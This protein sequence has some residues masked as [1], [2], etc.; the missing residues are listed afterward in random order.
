MK[1]AC[2]KLEGVTINDLFLAIVGGAL[3]R[4][5]ESKEELPATS[6]M[7]LMPISVREEGRSSAGGN[8]VG[9][10]PV[11]V[12]SDIADPLRRLKAVHHDSRSAKHG[13]EILGRGFLK[14]VLDELPHFAAEAFIRYVIYPQLNVT[15]SNVRG[16]E[17]TLY[18]AGARL[19]HFYPVSIATDYVGLNHTGFSYNGVLWISAVAC[20][21]MLPDPGFYADCLRASFEELMAVIEALP[22]HAKTHVIARKPAV[23]KRA[24]PGG[25]S[26][27]KKKSARKTGTRKRAARKPPSDGSG[28]PTPRMH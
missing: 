14:S 6:L 26:A 21:N 17:A 7:A 1:A 9:G 27:A 28:V 3:R 4:Y 22:E 25:A 15:V 19:V 12:H 8:Q 10:A 18:V 13:A 20:R 16:P 11:P 23:A 5:L 24:T 2:G